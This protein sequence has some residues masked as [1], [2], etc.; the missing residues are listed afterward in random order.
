MGDGKDGYMGLLSFLS[1]ALSVVAA[2]LAIDMYAL[3]RTGQFGKTWR[4]LIIATVMFALMQ[5]LRM[6]ETL[7]LETLNRY[8]LSEVV[9]LMF[10]ISLAYAFYLQRSVFSGMKKERPLSAIESEESVAEEV[11]T[12]ADEWTRISGHYDGP[13]D[14]IDEPADNPQ[15]PRSTS[16]SP[17]RPHTTS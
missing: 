3:L 1:F 15:N 17:R 9:E 11:E 16:H 8:H 6:G 12:G 4:V 7:N 2:V 10:V 13:I 14:G 5:A